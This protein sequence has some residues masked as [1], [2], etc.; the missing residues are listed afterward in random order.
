LVTGGGIPA[1][2]RSARSAPGPDQQV[3]KALGHRTVVT[4]TREPLTRLRAD[5]ARNHGLARVTVTAVRLRELA[6]R[7]GPVGR[8]AL[9]P[10]LVFAWWWLTVVVGAEIPPATRI[11]PGLRL[12]HAGRGV[13]LH[14]SC[15]IGADVTLYHRVTVGVRGSDDEVP[16]LGDGVYVGVNASVLGAVRVGD[17]ARIGAGSVVISDVAPGETRVGLPERGTRRER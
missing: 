2:H 13:V 12:P 17:G 14:P 8:L 4:M 1:L 3:A 15:V 9:A 10:G 5:L 11:G 7:N 16:V 6:H